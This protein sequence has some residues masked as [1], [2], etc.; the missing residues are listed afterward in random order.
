MRVVVIGATGNV[1]TAVMRA[2]SDDERVSSAVG[3]AR[4]LPELALPKV[5][6]MAADIESDPLAMFEG[7]DAVIHL[8]WKIQPQRDENELVRTNVERTMAIY[9][10]IP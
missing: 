1:G 3:V 9:A 8:A 4:R 6:W 7:A 5:S 2:L 10:T